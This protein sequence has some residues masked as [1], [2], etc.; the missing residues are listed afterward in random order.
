MAFITNTDTSILPYNDKDMKYDI[1][2]R[3]YIITA[4]GVLKYTGINLLNNFDEPQEADAFLIECSDD[5]YNHIYLMSRLD[6]I[7][8]KRH[9]IAKDETIRED[10]KKALIYQIRY[11]HRSGAHLIK[12]QHGINL[13]KGKAIELERI[14]NEV[15][16]SS[17]TKQTLQRIGLLHSGRMYSFADLD[18]GTY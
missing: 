2:L 13:E 17:P 6:T 10:F 11:A 1:D 9:Q 3:Q 8:Y 16:I 7:S 15:L 5:V 14:R 18:D 4:S 12:D